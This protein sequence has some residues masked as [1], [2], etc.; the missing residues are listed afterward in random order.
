MVVSSRN[1]TAPG[2]DG[3]F[4]GRVALVTGA[5]QGIGRMCAAALAAAGADVAVNWLDDE[6][7][8]EATATMVRQHGRQALL[9]RGDV[10]DVVRAAAMVQEVRGRF[11]RL[12]VL[13]NNAGIFPRASFLEITEAEWDKVLAVNLK[14]AAFCAQAAARVMIDCGGGAIV[15]ITSQALRGSPR[16]A[17]Y[18]ATKAGLVG[19]TRTMALEL[20]PYGI[21]VNA[22][23]PGLV[24]T[25]QPRG[26]HSEE[27]LAEIAG[28]IPLRRMGEAREVSDAVVFL[29]SDRSSFITG[30][31]LHVNGGSY[32][33]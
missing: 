16:G 19:L 31:L 32:M 26:G 25:A 18:S 7:E 5:Q 2:W 11:G 1:V 14:G 9:V 30:E 12:D 15:N 3:A 27:K 33:A 8:A 22:V 6:A 24:D 21:R 4:A 10:S 28:T 23:A 20:A 13:V 29:C 17:H